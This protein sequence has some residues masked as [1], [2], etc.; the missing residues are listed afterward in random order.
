MTIIIVALYYKMV[1]TT[2]AMP[3]STYL[4]PQG[5]LLIRRNYAYF[6]ITMIIAVLCKL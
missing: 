5:T 3:F 6:S 2:K 4:S 1:V